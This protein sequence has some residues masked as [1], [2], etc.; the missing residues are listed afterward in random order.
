MA[1]SKD[2]IK[3]RDKK[4]F[5]IQKMWNEEKSMKDICLK[6]NY[7]PGHLAQAM[8]RMRRDG[9]DIPKRHNFRKSS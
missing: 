4:Y 2:Q 8:W 6:I 5:I 3:Q 1:L 7:T 9:W